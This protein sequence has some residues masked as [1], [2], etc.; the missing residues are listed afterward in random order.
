MKFDKIINEAQENMDD[1]FGKMMGAT[2]TLSPVSDLRWPHNE[3]KKQIEDIGE[4]LKT[5]HTN[6]RELIKILSNNS[7]A[8][9]DWADKTYTELMDKED[10]GTMTPG[11]QQRFNIAVS[12]N[13]LDEALVDYADTVKR[14]VAST[15]KI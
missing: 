15:I 12:I 5:F 6:L 8:V 3:Q 14:I 2:G 7:E 1:V 11:E 9:F 13:T 10:E 4:R